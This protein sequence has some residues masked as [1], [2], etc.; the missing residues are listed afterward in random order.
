[1]PTAMPASR[2]IP[3]SRPSARSISFAVGAA[4]ST[5][6]ALANGNAV[7]ARDLPGEA[8]RRGAVV[9]LPQVRS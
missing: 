8:A 7:R 6:F 4:S 9:E 5:T 2:A 1:M 3:S